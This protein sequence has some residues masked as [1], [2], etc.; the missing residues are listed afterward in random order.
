[1]LLKVVPLLGVVWC[2]VLAAGQRQYSRRGVEWRRFRGFRSDAAATAC[3]SCTPRGCLP[4]VPADV[5]EEDEYGNLSIRRIS[6]HSCKLIALPLCLT[7]TGLQLRGRK[8]EEVAAMIDC[9]V[10]FPSLD[11]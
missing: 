7:G 4:S 2:G 5:V 1:M 9:R 8:E 10:P 3:H 6:H 11:T